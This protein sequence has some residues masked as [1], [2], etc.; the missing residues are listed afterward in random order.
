MPG[1]AA[2]ELQTQMI[3]PEICNKPT[4]AEVPRLTLEPTPDVIAAYALYGRSQTERKPSDAEIMSLIGAPN[5]DPCA[6]VVA[7]LAFDA[8]SKDVLWARS[9]VN[10]AISAANQCGDERL[11]AELLI[12]RVPYRLST[13]AI[14]AAHTKKKIRVD[15]KATML[16]ITRSWFKA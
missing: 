12:H 15:V 10:N 16:R 14:I 4:A 13:S 8:A 1:T 11:R 2:E 5:T 3:D 9:V 6:R 7:T